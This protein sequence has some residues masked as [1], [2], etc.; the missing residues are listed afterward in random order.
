MKN[1]VL[2][3][4]IVL[5][6]GVIGF[7]VYYVFNHP[8]EKKQENSYIN[9]P[10]EQ[11]DKEDDLPLENNQDEIEDYVKLVNVRDE[12]SKVIQ[13][14]EMVLNGEKQEFE[15]KFLISD[16]EN[17]IGYKQ[18]VSEKD[19]NNL[20]LEDKVLELDSY[21][22]YIQER[23][24]ENNFVI[25]E[26]KDKNYLII[27]TFVNLSEAWIG[28]DYLVYNEEGKKIGDFYVIYQGQ[29]LF[30]NNNNVWYKTDDLLNNYANLYPKNMLD[31][32]VRV[33]IEEN[34]IYYLYHTGSC[35]ELGTLEERVYTINND[36]FEY[37]I[38]NTY[39]VVNG[40]GVVC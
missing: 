10:K 38:I 30:L 23:F 32:Q 6:M 17:A 5:L 19:E 16:S 27:Q 8:K 31:A 25:F 33:R 34:N 18:I 40:A 3:S 28:I 14:Y 29:S 7:E 9:I 35:E 24:N 20:F 12:E 15:V 2:I 36:L 4:V 11:G 37:K 39:E 26:G 1:G 21:T 22:S 13:E